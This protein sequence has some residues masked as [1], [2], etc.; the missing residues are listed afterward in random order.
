MTTNV[1]YLLAATNQTYRSEAL[2]YIEDQAIQINRAAGNIGVSAG[3]IA[4]AMAEESHSYFDNTWLQDALDRYALSGISPSVASVSLV[5]ALTAGPAATY[6]WMVGA[7]ILP[8]ETRRTQ[9]EWEADYAAVSADQNP[10]L[11]DKVLHPVLIDAGRGNVKIATAITLVNKYAAQYSALGL[12]QYLGDYPQLVKDLIDPAS[13]LTAKLYGLYLKEGEDWFKGKNAYSGQWNNLPQEFRDALLVSYTNVGQQKMEELWAANTGNGSQFYW[14][15]PLLSTGGGMNHLRNAVDIGQ[16]IGLSGY[17]GNITALDSFVFQAQSDTTDG[18][19]YRSAL[20]D[21]RFTALPGLDYSTKNLNGELNRYDPVT[22]QGTLTDSWIDDRAK[23]LTWLSKSGGAAYVNS[24]QSLDGAW[25]FTD[26]ATGKSVLVQ[27]KGGIGSADHHVLF[28]S[29]GQSFLAGA[30]KSDRL[31]GMGGDDDIRGQGGADYLEGGTG[32]DQIDGADGADTLV[33]GSGADTLNG[34]KDSDTLNGGLGNDTYVFKSGDGRDWIEDADGSG[35]I[36]YDGA[37]LTGGKLIAPNIWRSDDD[38]FTYSIYNRTEGTTT[39]QILSIQGPDGGMWAKKWQ[40][41]QLGIALDGAAEPVPPA[42]IDRTILGDLAPKDFDP[43]TVGVQTQTDDLGNVILDETKPEPDR[44]DGL[45][46]SAG[47]D[48]IQSFGGNDVIF[49]WRGGDDRIE[50]GDGDDWEVGGMGNDL[51]VGGAGRDVLVEGGDDDKLYADNVVTVDAAIAAE[52]AAPS[53][54]QGEALSGG[55][56]DDLTVGGTGNDVL[57][58]GTGDD[59]LVAG[60]G[61]DDIDGD[62]MAA[63]IMSDW[64]TQRNVIATSTGTSYQTVYNQ[65]NMDWPSVGGNDVIYA[66]AGEDWVSAG[67]GNDYVDGGNDADK[68]WGEG[69]NDDLFGGSGNDLI[70][71]DNARLPVVE[72]GDDYLDGEDGDDTLFGEG[73]SDQLFGGAG[74]DKLY[75]DSGSTGAGSDTLDGEDGDDI[76]LGGALD[77]QLFGGSGNDILQGDSGTGN[78]D[79]AD[80]LDGE[81]GND[82]LIGEGG[83]DEIHGGEGADQIAG[84]NGGTD[85]SGDADTIY[86]EAGND[87]IDGQGGDDVIDGGAD[88]DLVAGGEGNDLIAGGSGNDQLQGGA[89]DDTL[90]GGDDS[91]VLFGEAGNDTI[92]GGAG[93][94]YLIG[95][96]GDDTLDG[97]AGDDVYYYSTGEGSDHIS[98]AGGTD[99][100]VLTDITWGQITLGVGSLKLNLPN[101]AELHLDDFDPDNPY[102]A[103]GIEY[104]QFADGSVLT[105]TQLINA[106]GIAPTGTPE[107]D[108]LSGTALS[109][110]IQALAGDDVV[111]A[112]AG[113]DTIYA[114]DGADVV[115]GGDGN[116]TIYGGNGDDVLLGENGNDTL[117]GEAGN[118]LLAGGA[119]TDQLMGGDGDDTYLFQSGD[120]QDTATDTLGTNAIALGSGLTLDAIAFSRQGSDLAVSIKN[121]TDRL[122]VKNWF[123]VDS[124]FASVTLGDGTTLDHAGVE[125]A[126]PRNQAPLATPDSATVIEDSF[127]AA[128]GNALANDSDP[129]GRTLR[130]TNPGSYAGAVGTLAL[131]GNGAY[132]YSLANNSTAV[133]SLGAGQTLTE[134]F[135]YTVTDD[136]PNGAA[137]AESSIRITVQGSNDL[138]VLGTDNASTVEDAGPIG[139]NVLANDRD[140]DTGTVLT[141]ANAG[142]RT[143]AYGSLTLG[144]DGA[145]NYSLS[146]SSTTVQSLAAGQTVTDNFAFNVGD[147]VALVGGNLAVSIGGQNDA[148]ILVTP[149]ADQS[150]SA[151]SSWVWQVPGGSFTDIDAGDMLG[152]TAT[153][154]DGTALPSW[155]AFDAATQTLSGRVPKSA[156][157]SIDIRVAATDRQGAGAADAFTLNFAAGTGGGGSGGNDGSQGN[158][159]VGNGVDAPPP[160][161]DVSFNDGAGTS[162][163]DPG[164]QG[165]NGYQPPSRIEVAIAS[166]LLEAPAA[167]M[168]AHGNSAAAHADVPGQVKQAAPETSLSAD[169]AATDT[170][171]KAGAA[172]AGN[173]DTGAAADEAVQGESA[174]TGWLLDAAWAYLDSRGA[175]SSYQPAG[176]SGDGVAAF[177]RW[178]AVEQALARES[179]DGMPDWLDSAK[180]ADLRGLLAANG[181]FLGSNQAFGTDPVSLLAGAGLKNFTGLGEGVQKIA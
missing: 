172:D 94:D 133:Q 33:G 5:T 86:G 1:S 154:A 15:Q 99:W 111:T 24:V 169:T 27:P 6:A 41:G 88:N 178:L 56:G 21:L 30:D 101:G 63:N 108:V 44:K 180:G 146:N 168:S 158:E 10:T 75:A 26:Y 131:N 162:P 171:V 80:Y 71:G 153:L 103:G 31:Y 136:D 48:L 89:G 18:I 73:G 143:G 124:H 69:G 122:T 96:L 129:E 123:A 137:T 177:A 130:V 142:T 127:L 46:D 152:Y 170:A 138:P 85:T 91:D 4:G 57:F 157:G 160:G 83:S 147:G 109:E 149:L 97:G 119:G 22:S 110:T 82:T 173:G 78:G 92:S 39:Y 115:Y 72:H 66:G 150:A 95:G 74:N 29:D 84:D 102:A 167:V 175:D 42:L 179:A 151:N 159:G 155:L 87:T 7:T 141:V 11:L 132:T 25:N 14:P 114:G 65:F 61:N 79:G 70:N 140:I 163:G 3:A 17:G 165:G 128:S 8:P 19:A 81:A 13:D 43:N 116:D 67:Y 118:D 134:N 117:M 68:L 106:L 98:D 20:R 93:T 176:N 120:G 121:S 58:G 53:G 156:E 36:T 40:N 50:M 55:D 166:A 37:V 145:W 100:L 52:N 90:D 113:S 104:F 32:N 64:S 112:R 59:I 135:A 16:R 45:S 28:G 34:G 105:K 181:G 60:A 2:R 144:S 76:L 23:M 164:A 107:A 38:K 49:S 125:A 62:A 9:A 77:D 12:T 35:Q 161:H 139:G 47:N 148:P 174:S 54:Q 126:M 51:V